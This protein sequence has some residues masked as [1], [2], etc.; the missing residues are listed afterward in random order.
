M[1]EDIKKWEKLCNEYLKELDKA[2]NIDEDEPCEDRL[3]Q[4][5][6]RTPALS[7]NEDMSAK[8]KASSALLDKL[9]PPSKK[10]REEEDQT[11]AEKI[12]E[13]QSH[14]VGMYSN[15]RHKYSKRCHL[16]ATTFYDVAMA[17]MFIVHQFRACS[18]QL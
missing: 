11:E 15:M 8:R 9:T 3:S 1:G 13:V 2:S 16:A 4:D 18:R 12:L 17:M 14:R 10:K 5:D 6:N 7:T